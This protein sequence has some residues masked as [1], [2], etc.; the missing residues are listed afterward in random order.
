MVI[1][2]ALIGNTLKSITK[3][4]AVSITGSTGIEP[5]FEP[6]AAAIFANS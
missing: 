4:I 1:F 6:R 3:I 2:V 5:D